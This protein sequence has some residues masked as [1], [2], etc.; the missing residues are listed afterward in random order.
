MAL[1]EN[2]QQTIKNDLNSQEQI[3][4]KFI[5]SERFIKKYKNYILVLLAIIIIYFLTNFIVNYNE[6]KN[7]QESNAIFISLLKDPK[8][9]DNLEKLKTKNPNLY[10]IFLMST[11]N[12]TD[13][14]QTTKLELDPL[15]KQIILAQNNEDAT[16]L[17]DYNTLLNGYNFLKNNDFKNAQME[18]EKIPLNSPLWQ[19]IKSLKHY[20]GL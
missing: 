1:K 5:K 19:L 16:F 18:F 7:T 11:S 2:L 15:L 20:Q 9:I 17:K 10:A 3:M 12:F 13:L 6:E 4:E 8:N 14:N